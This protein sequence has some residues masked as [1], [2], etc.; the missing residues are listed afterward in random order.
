MF[1]IG[2]V[3]L[4]VVALLFGV[5]AADRPLPRASF[6]F[7][8]KGDIT[9]LDPQ[10]ASWM[11]DLRA[12][13]LLF[14]GLVRNDVFTWDYTPSPAAASS[15]T[16]SADGREYT[17]TIRPDALWSNGQPLLPS[18]IAFGW[19]RALLP[20]TGSDYIKQFHLIA[21]ADEFTTWRTKAANQ[22]AAD[23]A[24]GSIPASDRAA[25]ARQLWLDTKS[26]FRSTVAI[27]ANDESRTLTVRLVRPTPH[28]LDL[29]AFPQFAPVYPPLIEHFLTVDAATAQVRV[30]PSWTRPETIVSNGAFTLKRWAF[31][32]E[33]RLERSDTYWN[34]AHVALQSIS[35][36][37]IE[38]PNSAVLACRAGSVDWLS[39]VDAPYRSEMLAQKAAF[40]T[41]HAAQVQDLRAQGLDEIEIDRRLPADPRNRIISSPAFGTYFYNFNCRPTLPGGRANPFADKR[42]RKAFSLT[43]DREAIVSQVRRSGE[44]AARTLIPPGSIG[45]YQSPAGLDMNAAQ[46]REL[47]AQAGYPGGKGLPTIEMLFNTEGGHDLIA[48]VVARNWREAL[49]VEVILNQKEIKTL[50]DDLRSGNFMIARGSWFG[51]YG[52]PTT[53]L[54][55][56]REGDGNNDTHF[57]SAEFEK[58]MTQAD[59]APDRATRLA[60]HSRAEAMLMEDECPALPVFGYLNFYMF[61]PHR[62]TG[63]SAHPRSE[64]Q[65][66]RIDVFGDGIGSDAVQMLPPRVPQNVLT[67]S[68]GAGQ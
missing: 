50:R 40:Y 63:I 57:A 3:L 35:I 65:M 56:Y 23:V 13:R 25:R 9:T 20:E 6:T 33:M 66:F 30:D 31:K 62:F 36:P 49:G 32:R 47:L 4:T 44:P 7:I 24:T 55:L 16:I 10:T 48:R 28:F 38:D 51:D 8:N 11:Q 41:E 21:G 2:A 45:G 12:S 17:F 27:V 54:N 26:R 53:F 34:L 52:D 29:C 15:W 68:A 60:L 19:M 1:K 58:L 67:E 64:Q 18:H 5:I 61:D 22:F 37:T 43:I 14:E 42:V 59:E 46:A 39:D